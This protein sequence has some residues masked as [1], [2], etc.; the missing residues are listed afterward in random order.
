[1]ELNKLGIKRSDDSK[2]EEYTYYIGSKGNI[3]IAL[4]LMVASGYKN[5]VARYLNQITYSK[6]ANDWQREMS[7]IEISDKFSDDFEGIVKIPYDGKP[8]KPFDLKDLKPAPADW[9]ER[10]MN[11][12]HD[13]PLPLRVYAGE[14]AKLT[15]MATPQYESGGEG[16]IMTC[17]MSYIKF[18]GRKEFTELGNAL[19]V[20]QQHVLDEVVRVLTLREM[21]FNERDMTIPMPEYKGYQFIHSYG[22]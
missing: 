3:P 14:F 22:W 18:W 5:G 11:P 21:P 4:L 20:A 9:Q 15:C 16:I 7:K 6:Q 19:N 12:P 17:P 10:M 8:L 13:T 2:K 1:M